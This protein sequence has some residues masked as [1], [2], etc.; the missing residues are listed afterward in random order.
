MNLTKILKKRARA[1]SE[2]TWANHAGLAH[3]ALQRAGGS[4]EPADSRGPPVSARGRQ[5]GKE[6]PEPPDQ[7]GIDGS[8]PSPTSSH[9]GQGRNPSGLREGRRLT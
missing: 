4:P 2:R 8:R 3:L 9:G 7:V 1:D 6:R 5:T